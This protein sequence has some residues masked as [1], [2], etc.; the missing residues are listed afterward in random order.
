M[1]FAGVVQVLLV[2]PLLLLAAAVFVG[3]K[4]THKIG[5]GEVGLVNKIVGASLADGQLIATDGQAGYQLDLLMPGLRFKLWPL[6]KVE[7]YPWVQ[8]PPGNI[9]VVLAQ[10]GEPLPNGAKS[11]AFK[12]EFGSFVDVKAFLNGGGQR[13][14]QRPV[15]PPGT[16]VPIHPIAF[17]VITGS[18]TF[19]EVLSD[20]TR[21]IMETVD[22][23]ALQ[24]TTISPRDGKD[25]VGVV[26]TL[27]GPPSG[28]IASRIGGFADISEMETSATPSEIIQRVLQSKNNLHNNYQDFTAFLANGGCIGLQHDPLLYGSYLL[29]PFLVQVQHFEML[30]IEQGQVAVIKSYVGLPTVDT[31]G[32][33]FKFGA[34]V[35]PGHQGIWSEPLRTGKYPLNPRIYM[36]VMVPTSILTLN[37]SE[38]NSEAHNLDSNLSAIAAKSR[39][40]FPFAIDLQ[41]QI[42]V[43]DTQA[44]RVISMVGTME[45]LVNEVLQSAVGNHFRN[46]LQTLGA[47][48]FI[49]ERDSVQA[50]AQRI[51]TDFLKA[52]H[53]E[54]RGV[55]IQDVVFPPELVAVLTER[56]IASQQKATYA[57]QREAEQA[58]VEVEKA[59]GIANK[60][61]DLASA[62]VQIE[63]ETANASAMK[64]RVDGQA[65]VIERTGIA[66]ASAIAARG[67]AV[68][69]AEEA[70]GLAK[71]AAYTAQKDAIGGEQTA[72]V[73]VLHEI[74]AGGIKITPDIVSGGGEGGIGNAVAAMVAQNLLAARPAVVEVTETA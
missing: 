41:V 55:Y 51:I 39:D 69:S 46:K 31:S 33:E 42:H 49:E 54:T 67:A 22:K 68:A 29:N 2:L 6:N 66:E 1:V 7:T 57:Q 27:D 62:S 13:G 14:V 50:E 3:F 38:A 36:E 26:T 4:S 44:P 12:D 53:V 47:T 25:Y 59:R 9:G 19:G 11:A 40:A 72:L 52:Y 37:W 35:R 21:A 45:N 20:T 63:I 28:E 5:P 23:A 30:V 70:L 8:V 34:I 74:G 60:Q 32:E 18:E 64:A 10:V 58:R 15:L 61:G 71:A 17:V 16:T 43:P 73:A 48:E 24:V 56:E 65:S